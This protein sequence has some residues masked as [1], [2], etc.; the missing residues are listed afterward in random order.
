[1][2]EDDPLTLADTC[3]SPSWWEG[4][5]V[6]LRH[7]FE[8]RSEERQFIDVPEW[9]PKV[10]RIL[11]CGYDVF[12]LHT[13]S[14]CC[15]VA[16]VA[17]VQWRLKQREFRVVLITIHMRNVDRTVKRDK[18]VAKH[19]RRYVARACGHNVTRQ[20]VRRARLLEKI[21]M[22]DAYEEGDDFDEAV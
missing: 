15:P 8:I 2:S 11:R 22:S 7:H 19:C 21:V 20:S 16:M 5:P 6:I 18:R 17:K 12:E 9:M 13:H 4:R 3:L 1:M 10:D 14:G